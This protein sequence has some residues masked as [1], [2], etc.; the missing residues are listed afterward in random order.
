MNS[1]LETHTQVTEEVVKEKTALSQLNFEIEDVEKALQLKLQQLQ[2]KQ[3]QLAEQIVRH[4]YVQA[5]LLLHKKNH[6][7]AQSQ[8]DHHVA[9]RSAKEDA[10]YKQRDELQKNASNFWQKYSTAALEEEIE[11][12]NKV[13][14]ERQSAVSKLAEA[15]A[16]K[17]SRL[18]QLKIEAE[19][20]KTKNQKELTRASMII[21]ALNKRKASL[22]R[23]LEAK[24]K[25]P[26]LA[27]MQQ[28]LAGIETS[29]SEVH[30]QLR[31][32]KRVLVAI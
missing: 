8:R 9:I 13:L 28:Q 3:S 11:R 29:I 12:G 30:T 1:L 25:D 26:E 22:I 16:A 20:E 23:S 4:D 10:F 5:S 2:S 14:I 19:E 32:A 21:T 27:Q 31:A 24:N 6:S 17:Q 7:E 18:A 15:V